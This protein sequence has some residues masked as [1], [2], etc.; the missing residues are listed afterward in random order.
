MT[1]TKLKALAAALAA[2][3]LLAAGAA[4]AEHPQIEVDEVTL[5]NGMRFL[6]YEQHDSPTIAA[7]WTAHVGSVNERPGIT[8]ISHFFE[9]MMFKGTKTIG[10]KDYAK[11]VELIEQQEKLREAMR[12]E[13]SVMREKLRRGEIG[14]PPEPGELDRQVQ[15]ARPAVRRPRPAAARRSSSRTS[16]TRSTPRTAA[17]S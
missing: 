14:G 7:G 12:T 13:M 15:G 9:H 10:T 17:S 16:S 4:A 8:G 11:D 3:A 5:S 6:L 1:S 2:A